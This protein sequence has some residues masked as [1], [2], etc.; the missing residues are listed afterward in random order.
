LLT[1]TAIEPVLA[2]ERISSSSRP[3]VSRALLV[4]DELV[5]GGE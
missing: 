2:T 1:K 3:S 5:D 4:P